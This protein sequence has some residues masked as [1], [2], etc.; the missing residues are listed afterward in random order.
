MLISNSPISTSYR[1]SYFQYSLRKLERHSYNKS[2]NRKESRMEKD[3]SVR[4]IMLRKANCTQPNQKRPEILMTGNLTSSTVHV[5]L[6]EVNQCIRKVKH[7]LLTELQE[8]FPLWFFVSGFVHDRH[9][10]ILVAWSIINVSDTQLI[11]RVHREKDWAI[12]LH[13][14]SCFHPL[15]SY[16]CQWL[17]TKCSIA[18]EKC[19]LN[20]P[21]PSSPLTLAPN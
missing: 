4:G 1:L 2:V 10:E 16:L 7:F 19:H 11:T 8:V 13:S 18:P 12:A 15:W 21:Q 9:G 3:N 17:S 20:A 5:W 14:L 6:K